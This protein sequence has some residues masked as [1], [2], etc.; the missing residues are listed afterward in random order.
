M[1]ANLLPS[2]AHEKASL[3]M[4]QADFR[5]KQRKQ[6]EKEE[7]DSVLRGNEPYCRAL[8]QCEGVH[9]SEIKEW[10]DQGGILRELDLMEAEQNF[11]EIKEAAI[12]YGADEQKANMAAWRAVPVFNYTFPQPDQEPNYTALPGELCERVRKHYYTADMLPKW[13]DAN[14]SEGIASLVN[15][16]PTPTANSWIREMIKTDQMPFVSA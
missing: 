14:H 9:V 4:Q 1:H 16:P 7:G 5:A 8:I 13:M 12:K 2:E 3:Y 6:S 11:L 15:G 10:W